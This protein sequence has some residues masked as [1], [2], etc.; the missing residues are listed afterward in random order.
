[1]MK[2]GDMRRNLVAPGRIMIAAELLEPAIV[3]V[4]EGGGD[5]ERRAQIST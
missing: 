2:Q 5:D 4:A 3:A 1:M